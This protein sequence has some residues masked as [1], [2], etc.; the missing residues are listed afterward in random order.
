MLKRFTVL[1]LA[2]ALS[3]C[4][5]EDP[6]GL[7]GLIPDGAVRTYEVVLD[8]ASFL[9]ADTTIGGFIRPAAGGYAVVAEDHAGALDAHA[10]LRFRLPPSG[11]TYVDTAGVSR[12]DTLP[13]LI[14]GEFVA[15]MDSARAAPESPVTLALY[16][17]AE[18]WDPATAG[19]RLR[20]DSGEVAEPWAEPGGT[21]GALVAEATLEAGAD[22]VV[23]PVDSLTLALWSDTT[24]ASRGALVVGRTA[25]ARVRFDSFRLRFRARPSPRPDTVVVDS[26][27]VQAV[28]FVHDPRPGP[29]G[30]LFVAGTPSWRSY[31]EFREGLDTLAV[32]VPCAGRP[33]GC[34]FRLSEVTL[35]HAALLLTPLASPAGFLPEDTVDLEVR[36]VLSAD[37]VPIARAP[38]GEIAA[39]T[40][41]LAP[42][43]FSGGTP[44]EPVELAITSAMRIL[45]GDPSTGAAPPRR[46]TLALLDAHEGGGFGIAAFG[47][48]ASGAAAPKLRLIVSAVN[49]VEIP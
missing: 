48:A 21:P 38:L 49:E 34:T 6:V 31:I 4:A 33:E 10:L 44:A 46:P 11:V 40:T 23:F 36:S 24:D 25:G 9:A 16:R 47:S 1:V 41:A 8:A 7:G 43:T 19:W 22:S 28:T 32:T 14:G 30:A 39:P 17:T 3:G 26:V 42:A 45:L 13:K 35:N 18:T 27:G 2:A 20:V 29:D 37:R 12:V 5:D 15:R